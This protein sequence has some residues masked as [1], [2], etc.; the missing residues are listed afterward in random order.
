MIERCQNL[1]FAVE[2]RDAVAVERERFGQDLQGDVSFETG[3][4]RPVDLSHAPFTK[5][6]HDL[7]SAE[8]G[9]GS[10]TQEEVAGL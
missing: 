2:S 3:V 10:E 9:A 8:P 1:R 7:I 4:L 6:G 5:Q